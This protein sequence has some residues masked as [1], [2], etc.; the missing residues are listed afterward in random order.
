VYE[1]KIQK[2]KS[3]RKIKFVWQLAIFL[4]HKHFNS[5]V[6]GEQQ[7]NATRVH[8]SV[9]NNDQPTLSFTAMFATT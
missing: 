4:S 1:G 6:V 3:L 9:Y 8:N 7:A 5:K 2:P